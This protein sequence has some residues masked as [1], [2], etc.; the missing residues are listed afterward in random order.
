M[1][2]NKEYASRTRRA[3][4]VATA[5]RRA[6]KGTPSKTCGTAA[7]STGWTASRSCRSPGEKVGYADAEERVTRVAHRPGHRRAR[8]TSCST[9]ASA[10]GPPRCRREGSGA[11]GWPAT[12]RRSP[13]HTT[14]KRLLRLPQVSPFVVQ[15]TG[16]IDASPIGRRAGQGQG[17]SRGS[18]SACFSQAG[19]SKAQRSRRG[20][21]AQRDHRAGLVCA[22][23]ARRSG[24]R[25]GRSRSLVSMDRR[26][27]RRLG[28]SRRGHAPRLPARASGGR[29]G[30]ASLPLTATH[31]YDGPGRYVALVKAF[32]L[33]GGE[34]TKRLE[35]EVG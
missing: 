10:R 29:R 8:A 1:T 14:R 11:A 13:I 28:P 6:A 7:T 22:A 30:Q 27:V 4:C 20:R 12:P 18:S 15:H 21:R 33:L 31:A 17:S 26:L 32:D 5:S 16:E 2:F 25:A 35:V 19:R 23:G 9:R 3:T 24:A 34:T